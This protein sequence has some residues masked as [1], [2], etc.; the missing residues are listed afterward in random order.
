[1]SILQRVE[2]DVKGALGVGQPPAAA[3]PTAAPIAEDPRL[4]QTMPLAT[5]QPLLSPQ[6]LRPQVQASMPPAMAQELIARAQNVAPTVHVPSYLAG[7]HDGHAAAMGSIQG[8]PVAP[9][10]NSVNPQVAPIPQFATQGN[11]IQSA[12]LPISIQ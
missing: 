6:S 8:Q 1:M 10:V 11:D 3:P 9:Q 4:M 12:N 7:L 5:P 2:D